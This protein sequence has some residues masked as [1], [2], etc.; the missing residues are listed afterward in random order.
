VVW[1]R[2]IWC[3]SIGDSSICLVDPANGQAIRVFQSVPS[4]LPDP[5]PASAVSSDAGECLNLCDSSRSN[6]GDGSSGSRSISMSG[7]SRD[8]LD[9]NKDE[10]QP[11]TYEDN[12]AQFPWAVR[13]GQSHWRVKQDLKALCEV[14][15]RT[16]VAEKLGS[17]FALGN[18]GSDV[19][20]NL[21]AAAL[22]SDRV[23][24]VGPLMGMI[25]SHRR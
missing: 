15:Q 4:S 13:E 16:F 9:D 21:Y 25:G 22:K 14:A 3:C 19:G 18:G 10:A 11:C 6:Y 17:G 24:A 20:A 1:H 23:L 8:R 7:G 2:R 5:A 12:I